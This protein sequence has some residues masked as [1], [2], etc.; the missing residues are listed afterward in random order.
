MNF[1][2]EKKSLFVG[3]AAGFSV[4]I[5]VLALVFLVFKN[6]QLSTTN[7]NLSKQLEMK[8]ITDIP[9]KKAVVEDIKAVEET[10]HVYEEF[11]KHDEVN[12][13]ETQKTT[14]VVTAEP[15]IVVD[16]N[17]P[18]Y[19]KNK[20][21]ITIDP[22][23][24][25]IAIIIDD[26]GVHVKNSKY[27]AEK[28]PKEMTFSYLPY[29]RATQELIKQ[30][31]AKTREALLHLPTE[32]ISSID[33]GPDALYAK[34]TTKQIQDV[35]NKNLEQVAPYIVG[36]NN[37]MGSKFTASFEGMKPV[38]EIMDKNKL[39]FIDSFTTA[40][41]KVKEARDAVAPNL[42]LL[43][44]NI[45]LDHKRTNEFITSQLAKTEKIADKKGYAIA[46]GHPHKITTD[47][48]IKWADSLDKSKYQLVPIT[49]MLDLNKVK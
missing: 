17:A 41:T 2:F 38:L 32:P 42:P 40:K 10:T 44:R 26:V 24:K 5:L 45:F 30:E 48:L 33:P 13:E 29:G 46:I 6:Q 49:A 22:N 23:K 4:A 8:K 15:A 47:V 14:E 3:I 20:Q 35:T 7:Q 9:I 36:A 34:M 31:T 16:E 19:V 28:L 21:P 27:S 25:L 43:T 1:D 37:H 12:T 39:F 18:M 11:P